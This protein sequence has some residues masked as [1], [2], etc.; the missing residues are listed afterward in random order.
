M[1]VGKRS[2]ILP[3]F[4]YEEDAVRRIEGNDGRRRRRSGGGAS[5]VMRGCC[6]SSRGGGSM[7]RL[8]H[9]LVVVRRIRRA[10]RV[11]RFGGFSPFGFAAH[12]A[13]E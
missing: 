7:I 11:F 1:G 9:R 12:L 6:A 8:G 2:M 13:T 4:A 10:R 3:T 5:R